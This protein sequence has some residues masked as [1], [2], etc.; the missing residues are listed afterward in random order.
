M[1]DKKSISVIVPVYNAE[2]YLTETVECILNQTYK[3]FELLLIDDGSSDS[4]PSLCDSFA[5]KDS[6]V[7]VFHNE[8]MGPAGARNFG[9]KQAEGDF[10]AFVDSDDLIDRDYLE[11]L[12][13]T[14]NNQEVDLSL[15]GFDRFYNDDLANQKLYLLG[16]EDTQLLESSKDV[17]LLFTVPKTS[18]SGVSIW[19]KLYRRSIIEEHNIEFPMEITYEE[20]CCFN[21]IYYRHIRKA[22]T[23]KKNLYHY[24]QVANSLSKAY[25]E[26]TYRDLV[27]GYNERVKFFHELGMQEY[28][29]KLD[30]ILLIVTFNNMKK[31]ATSPMSFFERR[32][33][34]KA[35]LDYEE[36]KKVIGKAG[37][38]KV[39]MTRY[40]TI[41][42][43]YRMIT[44]IS[45]IL[46]LWKLRGGDRV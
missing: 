25:K 12:I 36:T 44:V 21:L 22:V 19:A 3:N 31:I 30:D 16:T 11:Q 18:L 32:K 1:D 8:N 37:L 41:A 7:R 6:R 24:R 15:C 39:R 43:R 13:K 38:S 17:A 10:I 14:F 20:D 40:L 34:Y 5:S 27:N 2:R 4:S 42:S 23:I 46:F 9:L 26:S 35:V 28:I 29:K 45:I 33:A